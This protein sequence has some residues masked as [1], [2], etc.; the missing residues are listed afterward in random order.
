M[1]ATAE[2]RQADE[3]RTEA[4]SV[5]CPPARGIELA[6][7]IGNRGVARIA[8]CS[9]RPAPSRRPAVDRHVDAAGARALSE[10]VLARQTTVDVE[11]A[12]GGCSI[13][14]HHAIEPAVRTAGAWLRR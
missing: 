12:P 6:S 3:A 7:L 1:I 5:A 14:Q 11:V 8:G 9:A 13:D 4:S 10:A 2:A